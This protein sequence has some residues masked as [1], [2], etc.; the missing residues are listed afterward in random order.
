MKTPAYNLITRHLPWTLLV[1]MLFLSITA[2]PA[3]HAESVAPSWNAYVPAS[4]SLANAI[5]IRDGDWSVAQNA[6]ATTGVHWSHDER[7]YAGGVFFDYNF[8][9]TEGDRGTTIAGL[10]AMRSFGR[11]KTT[12]FVFDYRSADGDSL[13]GYGTTLK[14]GLRSG[15]T[16]SL[17]NMGPLRAPGKSNLKV[18]YGRD[19]TRRLSLKV[20]AGAN[21]RSFSKYSITTEFS[22]QIR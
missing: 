7:P 16:V 19:L 3:A 14:Y 5:Y 1:T 2:S 9:S 13:W 21:L 20:S 6:S 8:A 4:V 10:Y 11:W 22:W 18:A 15:D 17:I 12:A